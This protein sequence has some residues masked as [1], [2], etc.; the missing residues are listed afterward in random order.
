MLLSLLAIAGTFLASWTQ[1][2]APPKEAAQ[3]D[4]WIGKWKCVGEMHSPD[5]K[6]TRTEGKNVIKRT[7]DGKVIEEQFSMADF[8]G[9]SVSVYDA[10]GKLWRQTWVDN[11]GGY[12]A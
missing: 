8:K 9:M 4:F 12:I 2:A 7:F 5:G 3:L 11:S 1:E 6:K 10:K